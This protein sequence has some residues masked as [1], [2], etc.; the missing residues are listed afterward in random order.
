MSLIESPT[1]RSY[2]DVQSRYTPE[3]IERTKGWLPLMNRIILLEDYIGDFENDPNNNVIGTITSR[4]C[5]V[6]MNGEKNI[7]NKAPENSQ[8]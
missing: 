4:I 1:Q 5:R 2:V 6:A 8:R 3:L 7:I